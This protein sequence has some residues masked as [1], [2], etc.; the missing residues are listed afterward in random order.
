MTAPP[1]RRRCRSCGALGPVVDMDAPP[2]RCESCGAAETFGDRV[3][4]FG[5]EHWA[6][7]LVLVGTAVILALFLLQARG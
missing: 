2:A 7:T 3:A 5:G 1:V 4:R 6:W